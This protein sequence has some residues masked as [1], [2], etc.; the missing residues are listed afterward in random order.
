MVA[1]IDDG[2]RPPPLSFRPLAVA[3]DSIG[4]NLWVLFA[5]RSPLSPFPADLKIGGVRLGGWRV[6]WS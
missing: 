5:T 3:S 6:G 1:V 2:V 4:A